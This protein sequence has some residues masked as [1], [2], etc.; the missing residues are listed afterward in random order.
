MKHIA[1]ACGLVLAASAPALAREAP[2]ADEAG[3]LY[4]AARAEDALQ[5]SHL[6][7]R[8]PELNA[9]LNGILRRI[10]PSDYAQLRLYIIDLPDFGARTLP[11]GAI[12]IGAGLVWRAANDAQLGFILSREVA[13]HSHHHALQALRTERRGHDALLLVDVAATSLGVYFAS[14]LIN[15][16]LGGAVRGLAQNR[17]READRLGMR[18]LIAAGY[19]GA[20]AFAL[21]NALAGEA[22]AGRARTPS[23]HQ[24]IDLDRA[25]PTSRSRLTALRQQI[26][27][28]AD[29]HADANLHHR[30]IRPFLAR[31]LAADL[32]RRDFSASLFAFDRL[33]AA[34]YDLGLVNFYRGEAFRQR[35][36]DGDLATAAA[37]Y[38]L[39]IGYA[40][41]PAAAWRQLGELEARAGRVEAARAA[42]Q[43]YLERAP[44][45]ED[46][47]LVQARLEGLP[48]R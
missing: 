39:A 16:G 4:D 43:T 24:A 40:D 38:R 21:S 25:T 33:A 19:D 42:L 47:A 2:P 30:H 5:V 1:L 35:R 29:T 17:E 45:A 15:L 8:D 23:Q 41:A 12:E 10:A 46:R 22:R 48:A 34:G 36:G 28:A 32:E 3:L 6:V 18:H 13:H 11:N 20:E 14:D 37:A 7:E 9:Y 31:W 27:R 44:A 26:S